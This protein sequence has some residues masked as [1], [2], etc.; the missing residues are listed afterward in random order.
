MF[1]FNVKEKGVTGFCIAYG[2]G[3]TFSGITEEE[4]K[5]A[6]KENVQ[7]LLL[8]LDELTEMEVPYRMAASGWDYYSFD[9]ACFYGSNDTRDICGDIKYGW[10][11]ETDAWKALVHKTLR[12]KKEVR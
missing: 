8:Y 12:E 11:T 5:A 7:L 9:G 10:W 4:W 6:P 1:K 3:T 2:C